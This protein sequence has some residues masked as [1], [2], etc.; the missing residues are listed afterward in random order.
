MR[1]GFMGMGAAVRQDG[2]RGGDSLR[3]VY[4]AS[5]APAQTSDSTV[6]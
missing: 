6:D 3:Y 5:Q 1:G 2:E 4:P